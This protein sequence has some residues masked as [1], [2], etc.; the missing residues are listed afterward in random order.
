MFK[1][2]RT[3]CKPTRPKTPVF[4]KQTVKADHQASKDGEGRDVCLWGYS[5]SHKSRN[6]VAYDK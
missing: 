3:R 4:L 2:I 6:A 1:P 5:Q